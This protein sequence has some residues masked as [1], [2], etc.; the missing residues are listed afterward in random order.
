MPENLSFVK[1][2]DKEMPT[3][4]MPVGLG[5]LCYLL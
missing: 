3:D 1:V 2:R 5:F 4:V